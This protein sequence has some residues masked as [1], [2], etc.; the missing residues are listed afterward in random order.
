MISIVT[1]RA[2][3]IA[4]VRVSAAVRQAMRDL[5]DDLATAAKKAL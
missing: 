2:W 1:A 3:E 5:I 4:K